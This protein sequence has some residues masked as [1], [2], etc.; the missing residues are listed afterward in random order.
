MPGTTELVP[1][2][3]VGRDVATQGSPTPRGWSAGFCRGSLGE[4]WQGPWPAE[5]GPEICVVALHTEF[6]TS[7][8]FEPDGGI[9]DSLRRS[10]KE[11]VAHRFYEL[12][13]L[14]R[15]AGVFSYS[16]ALPVGVGM[17]SSTADAVAVIR[18]LAAH[19]G[20]DCTPEFLGSVLHGLE[21]SD[22]TFVDEH[23]FYSTE[24][25][26]VLARFENRL[27]FWAVWSYTGTVERTDTFSRDLLLPH[28]R[29]HADEYEQ[30]RLRL[31][32]ALTAGDHGAVAAEA[33]VSALLAQAYLP[34]PLVDA[35]AAELT[36]LGALGVVRAHTGNVC[37]LL[38]APTG[39]GADLDRART[40][41]SSGGRTVGQ[42]W[43]GLS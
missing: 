15:P 4:L 16:S 12:T 43:V 3:V 8:L 13:G 41:L 7:V 14:A 32:R 2:A 26:R 5:N 35:C 34:D 30:S 37:G 29:E 22:P 19:H 31:G 36:A 1:P 18:A 6:G 27:R 20:L 24:S 28:Y 11:Q 38:F 10:L 21:R 9:S 42:G 25:H 33:T 40:L 23:C 17:S 39:G